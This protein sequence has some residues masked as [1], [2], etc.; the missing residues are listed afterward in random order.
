MSTSNMASLYVE[1]AVRRAIKERARREEMSR[2]EKEREEAIAEQLRQCAYQHYQD[3]AEAPNDSG[4]E[5]IWQSLREDALREYRAVE[6][7]QRKQR[8]WF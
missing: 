6:Q 7:S 8:N 3:T 1:I 2:R 5:S 4:F